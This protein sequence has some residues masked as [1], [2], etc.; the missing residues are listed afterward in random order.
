QHLPCTA[1]Q[2]RGGDGTTQFARAMAELNI[3]NLCANSP[4]AKGRIERAHQTLQDRVVKELR[5]RRISSVAEGNSFLPEFAADYN[6][7]FARPPANPHDAHRPL[8]AEHD[9]EEIFRWK[10]RRKLT[11]NLTLHYRR[12]LYLIEESPTARRAAG[13]VVDVHE[14]ED[15][16]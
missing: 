7:R 4:Q 15:G 11:H 5:L 10:E 2:P 6:S 9:L 14:R 12:S 13:K 8:R 3:D 16:S 1:K